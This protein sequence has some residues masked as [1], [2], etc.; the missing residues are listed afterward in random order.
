M[1]CSTSAP[2]PTATRRRRGARAASVASG[3]AALVTVLKLL[4]EH[5]DRASGS[6]MT[7]PDAIVRGSTATTGASFVSAGC[8]TGSAITPYRGGGGAVVC[9]ASSRFAAF[10]SARTTRLIVSAAWRSG[11]AGP[12]PY[13]RRRPGARADRLSR[14]RRLSFGNDGPSSDGADTDSVPSRNGSAVAVQPRRGWRPVGQHRGFARRAKPG[15]GPHECASVRRNWA[16]PPSAYGA[17]WSTGCSP[18]PRR[19]SAPS[20]RRTAEAARERLAA[21]LARRFRR[22]CPRGA[23]RSPA[24]RRTSGASP[25]RSVAARRPL[26]SRRRG[27]GPGIIPLK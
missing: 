5:A 12:N 8:S 20:R 3:R 4:I 22:H 2:S 15:H 13:P 14:R 7:E 23:R 26:V 19:R 27:L 6:L 25:R 21:V 1:P 11:R 10:L 17:G 18:C 24:S 16:G 9:S